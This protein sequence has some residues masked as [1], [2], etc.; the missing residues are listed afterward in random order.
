MPSK[1]KEEWDLKKIENKKP[2]KKNGNEIEDDIKER[3]T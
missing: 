2:N 1:P 3:E